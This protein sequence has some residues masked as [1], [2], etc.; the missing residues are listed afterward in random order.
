MRGPEV[1]QQTLFSYVSLEDRVPAD[2]PL[3]AIRALVERVVRRHPI[4]ETDRAEQGLLAGFGTAHR[5]SGKDRLNG[6]ARPH[7]LPGPLLPFSATC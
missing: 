2:H 6:R 5:C 4:L 7:H 1:S 3:R